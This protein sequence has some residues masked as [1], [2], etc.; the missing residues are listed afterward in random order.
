MVWRRRLAHNGVVTVALAGIMGAGATGKAPKVQVAA[1][2]LP[3]VEDYDAF[4]AEAEEDV[5]AAIAK[6]KG[7][8]RKD[9]DDLQE[10]ARL[11]ARRATQRWC[12]KRPQVQVMLLDG[13]R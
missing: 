3:L 7:A 5:L 9:A 11:A 6:L 12:G 8:A 4:V 13:A 1:L 10:A 2:G